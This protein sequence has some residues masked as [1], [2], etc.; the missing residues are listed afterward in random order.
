M[1]SAIIYRKTVYRETFKK[2]HN[3]GISRNEKVE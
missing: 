3:D 2:E 1:F